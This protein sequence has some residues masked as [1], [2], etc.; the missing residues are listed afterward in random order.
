MPALLPTPSE[1][2]HLSKAQRDKV[3][4]AIWKILTETDRVAADTVAD[5]DQAAL[6]Q[7]ATLDEARRLQA[8]TERDDE[9][10]IRSRQ[11]ILLEASK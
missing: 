6:F 10:T 9:E 2:Q 1:L 5:M 8:L 11:A 3:R 4:R 7:A